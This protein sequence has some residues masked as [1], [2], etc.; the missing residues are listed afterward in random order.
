[1]QQATVKSFDMT[2]HEIG[3]IESRLYEHPLISECI[4]VGEDEDY[5]AALLIPDKIELIQHLRE[6][7]PEQVYRLDG[8]NRLNDI[9]VRAIYC[10]LLEE[11]NSTLGTKRM[12][13]FALLESVQGRTRE[14]ICAGNRPIIDSLYQDYVPGIG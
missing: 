11:I 10:D 12:E 4:V 8:Y 2:I 3:E 5:Y 1:M 14:E 13:R 9:D 7:D 6:I